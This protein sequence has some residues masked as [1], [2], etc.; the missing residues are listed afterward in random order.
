MEQTQYQSDYQYFNCG[1]QAGSHIVQ[2][3]YIKD[4]EDDPLASPEIT[5]SFNHEWMLLPLEPLEEPE[6]EIFSDSELE[7]LSYIDDCSLK[8]QVVPCSPLNDSHFY[9]E[10]D[11]TISGGED[12]EEYN[13]NNELVELSLGQENLNGFDSHPP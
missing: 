9:S 12:D 8:E 5:V 11:L 1:F 2:S 10:E 4:H 3:H 13:E 7:V 6:E